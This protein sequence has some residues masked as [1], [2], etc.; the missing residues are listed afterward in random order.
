MKSSTVIALGVATAA[1]Y[2]IG[3]GWVGPVVMSAIW[4]PTDD[5]SKNRT[6]TPALIAG[7]A[8]SLGTGVAAFYLARA[9]V[10]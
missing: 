9:V 3:R 1:W 7:T 6:A 8:A 5:A 4:D 10:A 2:F